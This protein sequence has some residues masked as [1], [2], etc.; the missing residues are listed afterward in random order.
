M[1][2]N[3]AFKGLIKNFLV[4]PKQY[5][6]SFSS[7]TMYVALSKYSKML[8]FCIQYLHQFWTK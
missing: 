8:G 5:I 2:F 3:S 4:I 7:D 6:P 1:E